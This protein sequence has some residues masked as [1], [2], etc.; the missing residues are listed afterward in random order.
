MIDVKN[1]WK[2]LWSHGL[3][4]QYWFLQIA[5]LTQMLP[6]LLKNEQAVK[7]LFLNI[8]ALDYECR[9]SLMKPWPTPLKSGSHFPKKKIFI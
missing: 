3:K 5:Y 1:T 6:N 7:V 2:V 8:L 4:V 9:D